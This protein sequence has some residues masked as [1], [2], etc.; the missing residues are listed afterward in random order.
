MAA[1]VANSIRGRIAVGSN[2]G[3][4]VV[5]LGDQID[6]DSLGGFESPRCAMARPWNTQTRC[7]SAEPAFFISPPVNRVPGETK[8]QVYASIAI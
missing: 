8:A 3:R 1:L 5:R 7:F 2:T 4:G 6:G